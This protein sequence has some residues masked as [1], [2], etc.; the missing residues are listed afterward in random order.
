VLSAI[1]DHAQTLLGERAT[2]D[3]FATSLPT[4]LLF[5]DDLTRRQQAHARLMLAQARYGLGETDGAREELAQELAIY[6]NNALAIDLARELG[7]L[8]LPAR[9]IAPSEAPGGDHEHDEKGELASQ[10]S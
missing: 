8:G 1:A 10:R 2:V 6:P 4:M 5:E 7:E 9:I 3:Y